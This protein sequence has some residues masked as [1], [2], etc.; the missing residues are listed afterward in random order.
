[1]HVKMSR[2]K[3]SLLSLMVTCSI[4]AIKFLAYYITD[5]TALKSDA[6]ESVVNVVASC[7]TVGAIIF[8]ERPADESHPYGH[9]KI[10]FFS[11]AFEGGLISLAAV[12]ILYE[13]IRSY[14]EGPV[15]RE[16]GTGILLNTGAGV[17]NGLLGWGL[18]W[19]GRQSQSKALEADGKHVLSDFYTS[20]GLLIGLMI[21]KATGYYWMDSLL[22]AIIGL[23]LV[24]TGF[25][26]VHESSGALLDREDPDLN[27][28]LVEAMQ[29]MRTPDIIDV[30]A[31]RTLR[32]GR[33]VHVD[34]HIAV[35]EYYPLDQ[36]HD[37]VEAFG[38]K[39]LKAAG[40]EGE[41]HS[42][43]DPCRRQ[44][45]KSCLQNNCHIRTNEFTAEI[46][47]TTQNTADQHR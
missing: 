2:L 44:F 5:S 15:V 23:M 29:K 30:H 39:A 6:L 33:Y 34:I 27:N 22:A 41:F 36:A 28:R 40:I 11:A 21:V 17:L 3:I 46:T 7:F 19:Y 26:L 37:I 42:H 18:V 4:L 9:G 31:L 1:M 43:L 24:Y 14:I 16:L 10:E 25:K 13:A 12:L 20:I 38:I 8:A 32:S 47:F 35:P 45:C